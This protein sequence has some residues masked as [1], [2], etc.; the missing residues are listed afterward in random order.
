MKTCT[1]CRE[2]KSLDDFYFRKESGKHRNEC[3]EC[4]K[5]VQKE[6]YSSKKDVK[7]VMA[8]DYQ[9][10]N[11][12]A[13][14]AIAANQKAKRFSSDLK[15]TKQGVKNLFDY[16]GW[17]CYY[18]DVQSV[19]PSVMTLDHVVPFARGGQNTIQNCVP[20]CAACNISKK[21]QTESE[22]NNG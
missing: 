2:A 8:T 12:E 17:C 3:K 11:P 14:K 22:F 13:R 16:H 20:A 21:D 1:K 15:I 9:K 7:I 19:D 6:S 5:G 4:V 10:S 18:C